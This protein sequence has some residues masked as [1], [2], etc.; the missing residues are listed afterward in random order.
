VLEPGTSEEVFA[1]W[2]PQHG[3]WMEKRAAV[4]EALGASPA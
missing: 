4:L 3:W 2:P 1:C